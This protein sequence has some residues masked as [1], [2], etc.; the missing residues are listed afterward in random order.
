MSIPNLPTKGPFPY[1]TYDHVPTAPSFQLTSLSFQHLGKLPLEACSKIMGVDGG[2]DLSPALSWSGFD[3]DAT[4]SFVVTC[5]DPD[6]PVVSGFWHWILVDVPA[7]VT[8]LPE[9]AGNAV[10]DASKL[11]KGAKLVRNDAGFVGYL[12]AGAPPGHGQHRYQFV[13]T[14]MACES[15]PGVTEQS[16]GALVHG[17]MNRSGIVG[18]ATLPEC[19][20]GRVD[21]K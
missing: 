11:P 6:A 14:A 1:D 17:K 20:D 12:G 21:K 18:R 3:V 13:V 9:G 8:S 7:D 19:S 4:K 15:L 16:S 10:G 2:Q 5:Y